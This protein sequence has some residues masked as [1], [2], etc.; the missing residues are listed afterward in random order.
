MK[1]RTFLSGLAALGTT[2]KVA[3]PSNALAQTNDPV[4]FMT[5][6]IFKEIR[7]AGIDNPNDLEFEPVERQLCSADQ[8]DYRMLL[9]TDTHTQPEEYRSLSRQ[10]AIDIM[11]SKPHGAA[12]LYDRNDS[13]KAAGVYTFYRG[14][15][16]QAAKPITDRYSRRFFV[17]RACTI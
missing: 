10:E 9:H 6:F 5:D 7:K 8:G 4:L 1:R 14:Q 11:R 3:S 17:N 2:L 15:G 13:Y 16:V 12:L